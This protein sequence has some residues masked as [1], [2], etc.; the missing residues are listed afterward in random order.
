[1]RSLLVVLLLTSFA[2]SE[3]E[4]FK[5]YADMTDEELE[6]AEKLKGVTKCKAC[7]DF[8]E[9][10]EEEMVKIPK[11]TKSALKEV[12]AIEILETICQASD[13][14]L[15]C[16]EAAEAI[17]DD[18]IAYVKKGKKKKDYKEEI[19]APM[20]S[21]K[22][23]IKTGIED[24]NSNFIENVKKQE[25]E[26]RINEMKAQQ[27]EERKRRAAR[28]F[29]ERFMDEVELLKKDLEGYWLLIFLG[30]AVIFVLMVVIQ[31]WCIIHSNN[32]KLAEYRRLKGEEAKKKNA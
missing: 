24:M 26:K 5:R 23:S 21:W 4:G 8:V 28:S 31:V 19:C 18:L 9:K 17:E 3:E 22:S 32:A 1:M 29:S 20:C 16:E 7:E 12:R 6:Q 27:Q 25:V 10:V 14:R 2:N 30:M 13:Q 11:G 15:Y